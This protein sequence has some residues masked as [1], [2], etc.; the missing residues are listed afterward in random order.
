MLSQADLLKMQ[1]DIAEMVSDNAARITLRRGQQVVNATPHTV[2]IERKGSF[3]LQASPEG[4]RTVTR[5]VLVSATV[6]DIRKGD[7]FN[8]HGFLYEVASVTPRQVGIQAD[9]Y[10]V[11]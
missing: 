9:A 10:M 5:Y 3:T 1:T 2:R 11:Q 6:I 8:A 4:E 7:R